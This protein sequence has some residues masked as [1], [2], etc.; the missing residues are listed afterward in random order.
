[1]SAATS[2]ASRPA[3]PSLSL[4]ALAGEQLVVAGG[5][6][7]AGVGNLA[8][9]LVAARLLAPGAF[10]DLSA[11][12]ALYLLVHVPAA[13]L[14]AGS[15][16]TPALAD[17]LRR[18]ALL[19][20]AAVGI[21]LAAAS[22]PLAGLLHVPVAMIL[23]LAAA[24]PT[25]G[26]LALE[27]GRLYGLG[28]SRRAAGS[29]LAEPAVRLGAGVAL[30]AALG[31]VGAAAAVV[32]AGWTALAVA[33][34]RGH[35]APAGASA[36]AAAPV[37]TVLAFLGLAAVQNEDVLA[38]NAL[39][40][41]GQAGHFAVLST[42]GGVAAFA[43]TTVPFMLLPR[44]SAGDRRALPTALA[45]AALL[46]GAA[47]AVVALD[48]TRIVTGVFG[49]RYA[50]VAALAVPYVLSMALL[51]V[52]RVLIAH[53]CA[54]GAARPALAVLGAGIALHVTLLLTTGTDVAGVARA[55][56]LATAALAAAAGGAAVIRMPTVRASRLRLLGPRPWTTGLTLLAMAG[57]G[58]ALRLVATRGLWLD[59]ATSADQAQLPFGRMLHDL[60]TTDV[61]PPLHYAVL[62]GVV[63]VLGTGELALRLPSIVATIAL[64]PLVYVLGRELYDRRAGL[65]A[66]A[67]ATVA[68]FCV[69]YADEARMYA[70]FMLFGALALLMQVRAI[71]Y[72]RR[73]DWLLYAV[74]G[75]ALVWTQYFG[76]LFLL[77]Q[78]VGF[79]AAAWQRRVPLTRWLGALAV[80][81]LLVAPIVPFGLHQFQVNE[82]TGKGFEAPSQAGAG[83]SQN[84]GLATPSVYSAIANVVWAITG[85]HSDSTMERLGA[86]WPL[87][88]LGALGV[89]GRRRSRSTQLLV[90]CALIPMAG[91]F[92][93]GQLKPFVFEVRYFSAAVP[94]ALLLIARAATGFTRRALPAAACVAVLVAGLGLAEADQQLNS[95]NPRDYDFRGAVHQIRSEARPG[96]VLVY[97]PGYLGSVVD[98]Y[99]GAKLHARALDAGLPRP[100]PGRRVFVLASFQDKAP[101]RAATRAAVGELRRRARQ[102]GAFHRPQIRVW[103]FSR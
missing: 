41:G 98:Y 67:L 45:V 91:L 99:G 33:Y 57:A 54:T 96:D 17:A 61:H 84:Q 38:A 25:A 65:A 100:A 5:Q 102:T 40:P 31:P 59:E 26:L 80:M 51:G 69:W 71:R 3:A 48:P 12:L 52:T 74:A 13:S 49:D 93:L 28:R 27:R 72:G 90:A 10:A 1:M 16:L 47:V 68:P 77:A 8:F 23:V 18:R 66:A 60:G 29:L 37:A 58:L 95:S 20:G 36:P 85:Y 53:A 15:A 43:T 75:A 7:A 35:G 63:R 55:T 34:T 2:A 103:E 46:G 22:V 70:L 50:A 4:R 73:R 78:Q 56:L 39:L 79:A 62:W 92:A 94:V 6:L 11:F 19:L 86:L 97:E 64:I 30:G 88:M 76:V 9:S 87:A 42:L 81:A 24:A 83:A 89:L 32:L 44:A 14:S 21:G 101:F 82:A